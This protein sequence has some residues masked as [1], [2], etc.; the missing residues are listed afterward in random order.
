[1]EESRKRY[2]GRVEAPEGRKRRTGGV[3]GHQG[4][5][6]IIPK[7][8]KIVG[9]RRPIKCPEHK[10]QPLAVSTRVFSGTIIDL[11]FRRSGVRKTITKYTGRGGFCPL[12]RRHYR[13]RSF[14]SPRSCSATISRH[15][16]SISALRFA[17]PMARSHRSR[18]SCLANASAMAASE[19]SY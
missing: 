16:L 1:E 7:P 5:K 2:G 11:V 12:C 4:F 17:C 18:K 6:R 13:P 8:T 9:T 14:V 19:R 10:G 15:G 3:K